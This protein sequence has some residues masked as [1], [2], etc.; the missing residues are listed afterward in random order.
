MIRTEGLTKR[1][2]MNVPPWKRWKRWR[3]GADAVNTGSTLAVDYL[4]LEVKKGEIFG[5]LGPNGAGKTTTIKML[6]GLMPPT[7]GTAKVSG[8]DII[9]ERD[10]VQECIGYMPES[11]AFYPRIS[12]EKSLRYYA[13]LYSLP[14]A[15]IARRVDEEL[16][17][18]DLF[19]HKNKT[20]GKLSF[21]M[22]KRLSLAQALLNE[23]PLLILDEPTGGLD[24]KGKND[25]RDLLKC[26]AEDDITI[27]MSSHLLSEMQKICT[28]VGIIDR[29]TLIAKGS[30]KELQD[31]MAKKAKV[32]IVIRVKTPENVPIDQIRA[33]KGVFEVKLDGDRI[34]IATND[35][36]ISTEI[37]SLLVENQCRVSS[38]VIEE[39]ELEE[40]FFGFTS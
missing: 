11:S 7:S 2:G 18:V 3:K 21:G 16:R 28:H 26:L 4:D 1:Y 22:K 29:G 17:R 23:P 13:N 24:P 8:Y 37:N 6:I 31:E 27:F 40:I 30:L 36:D 35:G 25:F 32:R 33:R 14:R 38:V 9:R 19:D 39:P 20:C 12:V 10:R 34:R 15:D 5:F